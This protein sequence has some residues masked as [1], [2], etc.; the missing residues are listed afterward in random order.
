MGTW[1]WGYAKLSYSFT[2]KHL[3]LM[4]LPCSQV[5]GSVP[6][7]PVPSRTSPW[8]RRTFE[9]V[10]TRTYYLIASS[11]AFH[12]TNYPNDVTWDQMLIVMES[13][14]FSL[15]SETRGQSSQEQ[16]QGS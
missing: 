2:P 8:A 4:T 1:G 9:I 14:Q 6:R 3:L 16:R 13:N 15:L 5:P 12:V 10:S 11:F 7:E